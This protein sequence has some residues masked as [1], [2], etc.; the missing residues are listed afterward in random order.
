MRRA[1][2]WLTAVLALGF[3]ALGCLV[4]RQKTRIVQ[5]GLNRSDSDLAIRNE[6]AALQRRLVAAKDARARAEKQIAQL[7]QSGAAS[8][9]ATAPAPDPSMRT[10]HMSDILKDHPEYAAIMA[11]QARRG[12]IL[13]AIR[14]GARRLNLL[15]PEQLAKLKDLLVE[16]NLSETDAQQAARAAGL[17]DGSS[18]LARGD[19]R[20][21]MP[22]WNRK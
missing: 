17:T 11:A 13:P 14:T 21:P 15:P 19:Q 20:R 12:I 22:R 1:H 6:A 18:G 8:A 7:K 5:L 16:R 2:P 9:G 4:L 10:I 3:L